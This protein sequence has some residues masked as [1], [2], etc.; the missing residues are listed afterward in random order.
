MADVSMTDSRW[1]IRAP[2]LRLEFRWT[3]DRWTHEV[4]LDERNVVN[5]AARAIELDA[6]GPTRVVSPTYQQIDFQEGVD[7]VGALLLGRSG[8]HHFSAV[9]AVWEGTDETAIE[10]DVADRC[11]GPVESLACTYHVELPPSELID[12]DATRIVWGPSVPG[13]RR[14]DF[15]GS[16]ATRV[17]AAEAGRRGTKVQAQVLIDSGSQTHRCRYRWRSYL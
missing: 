12:A 6:A 14:L 10:I 3:G 2:G 15:E 9:F 13:G 17:V 4:Y 11:R 8:P 1:Q 7:R 5:L 16:E